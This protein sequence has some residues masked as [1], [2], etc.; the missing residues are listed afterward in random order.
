MKAPEK[1]LNDSANPAAQQFRHILREHYMES[2]I[3]EIESH[4][5]QR[6]RHQERLSAN[7]AGAAAALV[8]RENHRAGAIAKQNAGNQIRRS[9]IT[10]LE[11]KA[12]QFH[13][14]HQN[15]PIRPG[16]QKIM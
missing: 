16:L 1:L 13:R 5:V 9:E 4:S 14:N 2:F 12:R 15:V 10:P 8:A 11:S 6:I 3:L 7:N